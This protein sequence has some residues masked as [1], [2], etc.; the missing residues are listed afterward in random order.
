[1]PKRPLEVLEMDI[2]YI[3]VHGSGS[4]AY[5]LTIIDTFNRAA[6]SWKC[7]N[8]IRQTDVKLLINELIINYLQPADLLRENV[9]VTIRNDNG[10]QFIANM[11]RQHLKNNFIFQ[12]F[13]KP[14]TPEQNGHIESFHSV[15]KRAVTDKFEFEDLH[16]LKTILTEFYEFYNHHRIHSSICYLNPEVFTWAWESGYVKLMEE[17]KKP[18]KRFILLEKPAVIVYKYKIRNFAKSN[19]TEIGNAGEQPIRDSLTDLNDIG[20]FSPPLNFKSF[21]SNMPKKTQT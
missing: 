7:K 6:L 14:A 4:M 11:V 3:Y 20:E 10:S 16:H 18:M 8:S 2:K 9:F 5:L 12:E 19:E 15:L 21:I 1:L 17:E 13:T